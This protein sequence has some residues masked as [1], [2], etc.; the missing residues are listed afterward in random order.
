MSVTV[1]WT[2]ST[3]GTNPLEGYSLERNRNA[4]GFVEIQ[5]LDAETLEYVDEDV[6]EEDVLQYRV[7]AFD[8]DDNY[9][10][11]SNVVDIEIPGEGGGGGEGFIFTAAMSG[12]ASQLGVKHDYPFYT[13]FG[14]IIQES[15]FLNI[16]HAWGQSFVLCIG[17]MEP[18]YVFNSGELQ[19]N[20]YDDEDTLIA[21]WIPTGSESWTALTVEGDQV[22]SVTQF[23]LTSA[24]VLPGGVVE[25]LF[26]EG[27]TYRIEFVVL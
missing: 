10:A 22:G 8:E 6:A 11:Y 23:P 7:R 13:D 19:I 5:V 21:S 26:A 24:L 20:V 4:A 2:A 12:E 16:Q 9:G 18:G 1:S 25:Y 27:E 3:A 17:I 14:T 15:E